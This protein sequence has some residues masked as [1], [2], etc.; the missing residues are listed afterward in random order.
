MWEGNRPSLPRESGEPLR[1]GA[2]DRRN[3]NGPSQPDFR[4]EAVE[5]SEPAIVGERPMTF[6]GC[7][8]HGLVLARSRPHQED[9]GAGDGGRRVSLAWLAWFFRWHVGSMLLQIEPT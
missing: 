3:G 5:S 7:F 9:L 1:V 8:D 2:A 4:F 6:A